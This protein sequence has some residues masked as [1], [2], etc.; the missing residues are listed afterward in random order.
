MCAKVLHSSSSTF[1]PQNLHFPLFPDYCSLFASSSRGS[2]PPCSGPAGPGRFALG[3][4]G[5]FLLES[6]A[7]PPPVWGAKFAHLFSTH[8][9]GSFLPLLAIPG[10]MVFF[11]VRWG[12]NP[13]APAFFHIFWSQSLDGLFLPPPPHRGTFALITIFFFAAWPLPLESLTKF[14]GF[15][16]LACGPSALRHAVPHFL[17]FG[18]VG[19]IGSFTCSSRALLG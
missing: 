1:V 11:F 13:F 3:T 17:L 16:L 2:P 10:L 15:F 19:V 6:M 9:Q 5:F 12:T 7:V 18:Q 8:V 4:T 14:N